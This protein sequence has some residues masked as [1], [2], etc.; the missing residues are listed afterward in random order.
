MRG[1]KAHPASQGY[2]CEKPSRLDYYQ[3]GRDRLT[4]P[5]RRRPDGSFEEI[6]WWPVD[7]DT[8]NQL[9]PSQSQLVREAVRYLM[10]RGLVERDWAMGL[11]I[12][13]G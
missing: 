10:E 7:P 3:N 8:V 9:P 2:A 5:L 11:L 1:D 4:R 6:E 12:K 13:T